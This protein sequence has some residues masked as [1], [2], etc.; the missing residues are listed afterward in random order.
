MD[1][2]VLA[3]AACLAL[4]APAFTG[5]AG[6]GRQVYLPHVV[7]P[8]QASRPTVHTPFFDGPVRF[9]ETT[10][11]WFGRVTPS[12]NY[13]DV[14][15]GYNDQELYL[16]LAAFDRRIWYDT[17]PTLATLHAWDGATVYLRAGDG[18]TDGLTSS[19]YR[20]DAQFRASSQPGTYQAVYRGTG[21]G[22]DAASIAFTSE[23]GWRGDAPNDNQDDRGWVMAF[24][25][26]F[27]SL[28]LAAAP[29][30]GAVWRLA[31]VMH[32]RDSA[33]GPPLAD[34][35]WPDEA[36][37]AK[38]LTWGRLS[39]GVPGYTA[40]PV[41]SKTTVMIRHKL[42]GV[43]VT[44][45]AVGGGSV[46]G[47]GLDFWTQWGDKNYAGGGPANVQNQ[48]DIADWPCFSKYYL[49]FPLTGLPGG[50]QVVSATLTLHQ[51]GN[52]G[53]ASNGQPPTSS[54]IQVFTVDREWDETTITWNNAPPAAEN[55]SSATV[56]VISGCGAPGGI[57]WPCVPRNWDVSRAA[58]AAYAAGNPLRLVL[59][60]ADSDY[61][62]GKYFTTSE[63]GDWNAAGRPTLTVT[64]GT[65]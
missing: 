59:Y 41:K 55:V 18:A 1:R 51:M 17:N 60:S 16:Y 15:I 3:L 30:K 21:S 9:S 50:R 25:V 42:N 24:R 52:A 65:P 5:A 32:D 40:P 34:K 56:G 19:D 43:T 48:S 46:C 62:S 20:L 4:V 54:L 22:W 64:L 27:Q 2:V 8:G 53:S 36:T 44:D 45:A 61:H 47:D 38:P 31:V 11:F 13:A 58:A 28:G 57:P 14:R 29:P 7:A 33:A 37:T 35:I 63:S 6:G 39:F 23:P 26:P 10:V 12:E 49:T